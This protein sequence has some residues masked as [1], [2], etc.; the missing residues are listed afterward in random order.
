MINKACIPLQINKKN[1]MLYI[2]GSIHLYFHTV[3][4]KL[5]I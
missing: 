2:I 3:K 5:Y 4:T 1:R